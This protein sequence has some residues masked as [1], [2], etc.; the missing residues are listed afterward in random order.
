MDPSLFLY[1]KQ[2]F[3]SHTIFPKRDMEEDIGS[4]TTAQVVKPA[5]TLDRTPKRC[6]Q[7]VPTAKNSETIYFLS[8]ASGSV[9]PL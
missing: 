1:F 7:V 6:T 8:V 5:A 3:N 4:A 2:V 9:A